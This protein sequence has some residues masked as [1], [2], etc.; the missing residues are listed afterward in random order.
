MTRLSPQ[1]APINSVTVGTITCT[2]NV[3]V[4]QTQVTSPITIPA[5]AATGPQT[6]TVMFPGAP[7]NPN[8]PVSYTLV[9]GFT[10]N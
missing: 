9:N 8:P 4:S 2:A 6:V 10:I 7:P 3:H 5:G 1:N